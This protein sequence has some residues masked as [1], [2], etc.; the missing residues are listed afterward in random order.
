MCPEC[1]KESTGVGVPIPRDQSLLFSPPHV[2]VGGAVPRGV[3][4]LLPPLC[5]SRILNSCHEQPVLLTTV[6]LNGPHLCPPHLLKK[7]K[8][9]FKLSFKFCSKMAT[10]AL[11][12]DEAETAASVCFIHPLRIQAVLS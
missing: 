4:S 6:E 5:S 3:C 7:K 10:A 2:C 8:K 12:P 11:G 1:D 9:S